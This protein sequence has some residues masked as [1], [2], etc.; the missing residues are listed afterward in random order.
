MTAKQIAAIL[1]N[2]SSPEFAVNLIL[3]IEAKCTD[4]SPFRGDSES[5]YLVPEGH[6]FCGLH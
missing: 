3:Q 4:Y 1:L 6:V 2:T 5:W